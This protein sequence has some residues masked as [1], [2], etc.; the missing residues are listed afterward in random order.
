L[1][2]H[3][4]SYDPIIATSGKSKNITFYL[5]NNGNRPAFVHFMVLQD[6]ETNEFIS[7]WKWEYHVYPEM[8]KG[9]TKVE[10]CLKPALKPTNKQKLKLRL[11][12]WYGKNSIIELKSG[13]S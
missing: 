3:A 11:I 13:Y 5:Y 2:I 6:A 10:L 12:I 4:F 1:E 7:P 9:A 8:I